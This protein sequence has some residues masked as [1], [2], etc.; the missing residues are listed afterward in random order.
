MLLRAY[1]PPAMARRGC[2]AWCAPLLPSGLE[3]RQSCLGG[4]AAPRASGPDMGFL[5]APGFG[6]RCPSPRLAACVDL[7]P[8]ASAAD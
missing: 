2:L 7:A 6:G 4:L 1:W 8:L 3:A 5:F